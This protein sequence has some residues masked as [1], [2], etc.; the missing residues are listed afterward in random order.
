MGRRWI[1]TWYLQNHQTAPNKPAPA[2]NAPTAMPAMAPFDK[3]G[4]DDESVG[5][6]LGVGAVGVGVGAEPDGFADWV[7]LVNDD[8]PVGVS[9]WDVS[10]LVCRML[11]SDDAQRIS[12]KGAVDVVEPAGLNAYMGFLLHS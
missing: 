12:M 6:G 7:T 9:D 11:R 2:M 4:D 3:P 10:G 1:C 8:A 5:V